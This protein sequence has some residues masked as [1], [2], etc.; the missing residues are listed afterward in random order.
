M[1]EDRQRAAKKWT[2][3]R[4]VRRLAAGRYAARPDGRR[5]AAVSMPLDLVNAHKDFAF[6]H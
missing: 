6:G 2:F 4:C 5:A 1:K 3:A